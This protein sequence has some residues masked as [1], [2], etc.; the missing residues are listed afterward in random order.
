M[1]RAWVIVDMLVIG[2]G[3]G[4][5]SPMLM[6]AA[7]EAVPWKT[8]GATTALVQFSRTIGGAICVAALGAV[9][10]SSLR[11]QLGS[12]PRLL[13]AANALLD[14]RQHVGVPEGIAEQVR[15]ALA[16]GLLGVLIGIGVCGLLACAAML[17]FP[18]AGPERRDE[19]TAA[20]ETSSG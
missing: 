19:M 6:I 20:E 10:S 17:T 8:R 11:S 2:F 12:D 13:E 9:L 18:K 3:M 14:P 16:D 7:Q 4:F 5:A 1:A 15:A